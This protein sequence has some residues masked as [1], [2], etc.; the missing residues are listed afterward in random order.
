MSQVVNPMKTLVSS[1]R[2]L[3]TTKNW[4]SRHSGYYLA[5]FKNH[6]KRRRAM[7][8]SH[9]PRYG[10]EEGRGLWSAVSSYR[11]TVSTVEKFMTMIYAM[12]VTRSMKAG[13]EDN[14]R[15]LIKWPT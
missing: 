2:C 15:E 11:T 1:S 5:L 7:T 10:K 3:K 8:S 12:V 6:G 13:L 9:R 14:R 4:M